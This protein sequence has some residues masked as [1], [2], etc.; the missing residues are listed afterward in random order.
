M[1]IPAAGA[2]QVSYGVPEGQPVSIDI[3]PGLVI[4]QHGLAGAEAVSP[5]TGKVKWT[6]KL[7]APP[8]FPDSSNP[9][10]L[11]FTAVNGM[12][13]VYD[14]QD[15]LW[16]LLN[17]VTGTASPPHRLAA[18]YQAG[19][20]GADDVLP[21]NQANVILVNDTDV[22]DIDPATGKARW[23][24]PVHEWSGE[25]MIGSTLYLDN[26][27]YDYSFSHHPDADPAGSD[28]A[29][30]R[31]SL[32]HGRELPGLALPKDLQAEAGQV[33]QYSADPGALMVIT[34]GAMARIA[35][36][37]GR[38]MWFRA[39]PAG[40]DGVPQAAA[41]T[42]APS[43]EYLVGSS[44]PGNAAAG[45]AG[46]SRS[47]PRT[48]I[49]RVE[50]IRLADGALSSVA[51]GRSFP[52]AAA[53]I[54]T[55]PGDGGGSTWSGY[56][57]SLLAAPAAPAGQGGYSYTRLEGVSPATGRVLWRGPAAADLA[58]LGQTLSGQPEVIMESCPPSQV[59]ASA[60]PGGSSDAYCNA[61]TV[62]AVNT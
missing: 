55:G 41:G 23:Q 58:V 47:A 27:P 48:G 1:N 43:A 54:D 8:G 34:S 45:R 11:T 3:A 15:Y 49:W 38:V 36:A 56:G 51:L 22:Q 40:T 53:G 59:A 37:T 18:Y 30:Q 25:A 39:L 44:A 24:V 33:T 28:T 29:I 5:S 26:D 35:P 2:D 20:G 52:Y 7:P 62:Y 6:V 12:I 17:P 32:A 50:I 4:F 13:S 19:D 9:P 14:P 31:I 57:S 60:S 42:A 21:L 10:G 16:W 46:G 61:E